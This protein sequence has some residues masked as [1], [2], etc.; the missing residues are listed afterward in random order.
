M[1]LNHESIYTREYVDRCNQRWLDDYNVDGFRF[2]LAKGFTQTNSG[3]DVNLWGNYDA[4]RIANLNHYLTAIRQSYPQAMNI[5]ELFSASAEERELTNNGF[6][7]WNNMTGA[8]REGAK[9]NNTGS[10]NITSSYYPSRNLTV[11]NGVTYMESHDEERVVYDVLTNGRQALPGYTTRDSITAYDRM[12]LS[13]V[14]FLAVPGPKMIWQFG[15]LGYPYSINACANGIPN[16]CRVDPKPVRWSYPRNPYRQG[17][18]KVYQAMMQLVKT[19]PVFTSYTAYTQTLNTSPKRINFTHPQGNVVIV[20]NFNVTQAT[21]AS[22]L[23]AGRWYEF[24]SGDSIMSAGP[25]DQITLKPGEYRLYSQKRFFNPGQGLVLGLEDDVQQGQTSVYPNPT[26]GKVTVAS[27]T[28]VRLT[29]V[30]GR[31]LQTV[32]PI[33][34]EAHLDLTG[35]APGLYLV[36]AQG[37]VQRIVKQ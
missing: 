17:I 32:K 24:F 13:G 18:Y 25:S 27:R 35:M 23:T 28:D 15:E 12:K 5:L 1:D 2:D 34:G 10:S 16:N 3:N 31:V 14:F 6:F 11:P 29:D 33:H 37:Q 30:Q 22:N 21:L 36:H 9:G 7:V 20:G 8:Y 4:S 26:T 19:E